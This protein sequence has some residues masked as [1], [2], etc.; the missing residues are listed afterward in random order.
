MTFFPTNTPDFD[1]LADDISNDFLESGIPLNEGIKGVAIRSQLNPE[2]IRRLV[3]KTNTLATVKVIKS[4]M[5]KR[6]EFTLADSAIILADTH[7]SLEDTEGTA[8]TAEDTDGIPMSLPDCRKKEYS[9][10]FLKLAASYTSGEQSRPKHD[11]NIVEIFRLEN[12]AT[13]ILNAKIACELQV[14][15]NIDFIISEFSVW[16][17]PDF[18]KFANEAITVYGDSLAPVL[19]KI[20]EYISEPVNFCKVAYVVDDSDLLIKKAG[21]ILSGLRQLIY[22]D[23]KLTATKVAL[24][25]TWTSTKAAL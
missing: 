16:N 18:S 10:S 4:A 14:Q 8:K 9:D 22:I 7:G 21:D 12:E 20:A 17:A 25:N 19:A 5:D 1:K 3:E 11:K 2:Q 23:K 24:D 6:A 13:G 15:D